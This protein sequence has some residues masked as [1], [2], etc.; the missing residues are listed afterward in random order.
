MEKKRK[1]RR[2]DAHERTTHAR[3]RVESR[4][5][6]RLVGRHVLG[7]HRDSRLGWHSRGG[8]RF[9]ES[10]IETEYQ[11]WWLL[12]IRRA[13]RDC[14]RF[15]RR[16]RERKNK[17]KDYGRVVMDGDDIGRWFVSVLVVRWKIRQKIAKWLRSFEDRPDVN[18]GLFE[19]R[20]DHEFY[21]TE[22]CILQVHSM[23]RSVIKHDL[24][25][26]VSLIILLRIRHD[27]CKDRSRN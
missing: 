6:D 11:R 3:E 13:C 18:D 17:E 15:N 23:I 10:R 26:C 16:E 7:N 22:E 4:S 8:R 27:N 20:S 1:S 9:G 14:V 5:S 2:F 25:S 21:I 12:T 19:I 24:K